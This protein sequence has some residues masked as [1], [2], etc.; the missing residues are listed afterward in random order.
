MSMINRFHHLL[1]IA[2]LTLLTLAHAATAA[3]IHSNGLGGGPWSEPTTWRGGKIPAGAD[4][5][6]I[7]RADIV[8]FDRDDQNNPSCNNLYI[9]PQGSLQF[10][11]AAGKITLNLAGFI[12]TYGSIQIDAARVPGDVITLRMVG[13]DNDARTIRLMRGSSISI[14]GQRTTHAQDASAVLQSLP[15]LHADGF[16]HKSEP[17]TI[18]TQ[19]ESGIDLRNARLDGVRL[20]LQNI[21]NTAALPGQRLNILGCHFQGRSHIELTRCDTPVITDNHFTLS[22]RVNIKAIEAAYCALPMIRGNTITGPYTAGI[23]V[24]R[25]TEPLIEN[26]HIR[27]ARTGI[28]TLVCTIMI[29]NNTVTDCEYGYISRI[30][31]GVIRDARIENCATP[32]MIRDGKVQLIN[33]SWEHKA[34]K[35]PRVIVGKAQLLLINTPLKP[36]DVLSDPDHEGTNLVIGHQP[37]LVK[38]T[39]DIPPGATVMVKPVASDLRWQ[40]IQPAVVG[41]PAPISR[42][43]G[44][45]P[46][47]SSGQAI[48]LRSW[49]I[50]AAE[51]AGKKVVPAPSY[52][53]QVLGPP[54]GNATDRPVLASMRVTPDESWHQPATGQLS[55][56]VEITLP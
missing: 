14:A 48:L 12:E 50:D 17:L 53:V 38:V 35:T 34:G 21:D 36:E 49:A 7:A 2:A 3:D 39:G 8:T 13:K 33:S 44:L 29:Q 25:T 16:T 10:K 52:D 20:V 55:P 18:T 43:S 41:V 47:M 22:E 42:V 9:D 37:L 54:A 26:N 45:T 15:N 40:E 6:T 19:G 11:T 4:D 28:E 24:T 32:V 31:S 56:T 27:Q 1:F 51:A 5:V 30:S 46:P 23:S